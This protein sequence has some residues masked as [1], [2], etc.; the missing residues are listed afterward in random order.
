MIG[1]LKN[2][3]P[4]VILGASISL[5]AAG[6]R[7]RLGIGYDEGLA[8]RLFLTSQF[9]IQA[10]VGLEHLGGYDGTANNGNV[11]LNS[12]TNYSFGV[13]GIFSI[14]QGDWVYLDA[15]LQAA[16]SHDGVRNSDGYGARNWYFIRAALA[17]EILLNDRLGLGMRLGIETAIMGDSKEAAAGGGSQST[18]DGV[19]NLRFY[20]PSNPFGGA[21]LGMS[22]YYYFGG[23]PY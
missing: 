16:L 15:L 8:V 14:V 18:D 19:T 5:Q 20:G 2:L 22:V 4:L 6:N 23:M 10:N 13:G 11:K 1:N 7:E 17:P 3:I 21:L 12:E 9:G